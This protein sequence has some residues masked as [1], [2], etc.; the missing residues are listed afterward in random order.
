MKILLVRPYNEESF[1]VVPPLGL[2]YLATALRKNKHQ[3]EIVDCVKNKIPPQNFAHVIKKSNPDL[4]G[5]TVYSSDLFVTKTYL[6]TAK[7]NK[8]IITV[9]GGPHPSAMPKESME[10]YKNLLD[11]AFIGEAEIGFPLLVEKLKRDKKPTSQKLKFIPGL[12]WK[13]NNTIKIN[14]PQFPDNLDQLGF[15]SWDLIMP[16]T[17]PHTPIGGFAKQ[18]PVAY[19]LTSRSCPFQCTFCAAKSVHGSHFRR[20]SIADVMKEVKY[21]VDKRGIKELHILDDNFT[22]N[23]TF[24]KK[25]CLEKISQ[26]LNFSWNCSCGIRLDR[27]DKDTLSLMKKAGCYSVAVGIESGSPRIL[28]HM[29]KNLTTSTIRKQVDLIRN[30]NIEVTGLFILGYPAETRKDILQTIAFAK[31]LNLS[32]ATFSTFVPLPGSEIWDYLKKERR[33]DLS[34]FNK[35]S[36]YRTD[37]NYTKDISQKDF[38]SLQKKAFSEF[39]LRPKIALSLIKEIS[40]PNHIIALAKRVFYFTKLWLTPKISSAK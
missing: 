8:K 18:F 13:Q 31:S 25:F 27:I 16:E 3:V 32:K 22:L 11:F 30:T 34:D 20:R 17:Y 38:L 28:K 23:N 12:V 24:V 2:G 37:S 15:P 1:T 33:L 6:K 36:Y 5:I 14:P 4:V 7:Q 40:S 19:I 39:Y 21:L 35:L 26:K 9:I 10:L 29:K